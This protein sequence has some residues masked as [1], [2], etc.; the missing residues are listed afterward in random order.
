MR[1]RYFFLPFILGIALTAAGCATPQRSLSLAEG[2]V[3]AKAHRIG[4]AMAP[5]PKVDMQLPGASCLLCYAAA[6]MANSAL[7]DHARTLPH[8]D[9][10]ALKDSLASMVRKKGS[11]VVVIR[12]AVDVDKLPGYS[13]SGPDIADK[14]FS[15]LRQKY[16]IDKLIL[17][18]IT[19]LGMLRPY[20]TYFPT[21]EPRA[22]LK[23][24][25]YVVSLN[26][27]AYEWYQPIDIA[28]GA[29][30]AWDEPPT[31]PGLTNAYFQVLEMGKSA[32]LEPFSR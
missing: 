28:R 19:D 16:G 24:V 17:I 9:L 6:S 11:N 23:G 3:S 26:N 12:D 27:N 10:P 15:L 7:I 22:I 5:L 4:V 32:F 2:A 8:E 25:G 29:E 13:G 21:S 31:F 18:R 1:N 14:D 30:G 20:S